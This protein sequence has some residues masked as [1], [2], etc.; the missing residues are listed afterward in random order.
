[1]NR[2][3][4]KPRQI[5]ETERL[6]N[7]LADSIRNLNR[8]RECPPADDGRGTVHGYNRFLRKMESELTT[9]RDINAKLLA[10]ALAAA[11]KRTVKTGIYTFTLD[12]RGSVTTHTESPKVNHEPRSVRDD[13][14]PALF[15]T[16]IGFEPRR[17]PVR[18]GA[19]PARNRRAAQG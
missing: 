6:A 16:P 9:D 10:T 11:G 13:R 14:G 4:K 5:P 7:A 18:D 3:T 15:G 19:S 2:H 17:V 12:G 1:M 8:F